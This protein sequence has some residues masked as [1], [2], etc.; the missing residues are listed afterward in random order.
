MN[1]FTYAFSTPGNEIDPLGL[2]VHPHQIVLPQEAVNV[3]RDAS[4][5]LDTLYSRL[6]KD[7]EG[8]W[9]RRRSNQLL[10]SVFGG[11]KGKLYFQLY[12]G[13]EDVIGPLLQRPET[14]NGLILHYLAEK[15][16]SGGREELT[17]H[18]RFV[19]TCKYGWIDMGHFF[20]T[21]KYAYW[22]RVF[23]LGNSAD[24]MIAIGGEYAQ[25]FFR[26]LTSAFGITHPH[27][28]SAFTAEDWLSN[29]L[30]TEFGVGVFNEGPQTDI[31]E[32]WKTFLVESGA[33]VYDETMRRKLDKDVLV[34][35]EDYTIPGP[36][37]QEDTTCQYTGPRIHWNTVKCGWDD[38]FPKAYR[39]LCCCP[40][41]NCPGGCQDTPVDKIYN[42]K[43]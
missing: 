1:L 2:W 22:A 11:A 21:A 42:Y 10:V 28:E 25:E 6:L 26:L 20:L 36:E 34:W 35:W 23:G 40:P 39:L 14:K 9:L 27:S 7:Y 19:F 43:P 13:Y 12:R 29:K 17:S 33:V 5:E 32:K 30:G 31:A 3:V 37:N 4:G 16:W 15:N 38:N 18:N 24:Q 8:G 41:A